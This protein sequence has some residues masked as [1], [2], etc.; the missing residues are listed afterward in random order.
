MRGNMVDWVLVKATEHMRAMVLV[1]TTQK[2]V[3]AKVSDYTDTSITK[4]LLVI[5]QARPDEM[6]S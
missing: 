5:E 4:G 2:K 1:R 3:S 6:S